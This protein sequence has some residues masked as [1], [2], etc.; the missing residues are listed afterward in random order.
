LGLTAEADGVTGAEIP[1]Y[2]MEAG[3]RCNVVP[4]VAT[5]IVGTGVVASARF[6]SA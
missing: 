6:K 1:L 4:G 2:Q 3:V 5:A